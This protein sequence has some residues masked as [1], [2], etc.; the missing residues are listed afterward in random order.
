MARG[1][2]EAERGLKGVE[3]NAQV[4]EEK[5]DQD[6]G[7]VIARASFEYRPRIGSASFNVVFRQYSWAGLKDIGGDDSK[8]GVLYGAVFLV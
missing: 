7:G 1:E 6:E 2:A 5:M 4:K 3:G 8:D